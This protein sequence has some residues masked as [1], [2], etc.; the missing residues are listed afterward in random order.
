MGGGFSRQNF[1]W[2][3]MEGYNLIAGVS[4]RRLKAVTQHGPANDFSK[5]FDVNDSLYISHREA[6]TLAGVVEELVMYIDLT[7]QTDRKKTDHSLKK[8]KEEELKSLSHW[9]TGLSP[10]SLTRAKGPKGFTYE[11]NTEGQ[12]ISNALCGVSPPA[13]R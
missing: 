2:A 12:I 13:V 10:L 11:E 1:N 6:I 8:K 4:P 7:S 9:P 3:H 5:E